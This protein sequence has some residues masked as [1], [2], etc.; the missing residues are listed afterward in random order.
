M[1]RLNKGRKD[2]PPL[3]FNILNCLFLVPGRVE[4]SFNDSK[5]PGVF[6]QILVLVFVN[7]LIN[8]L[9]RGI[10][11]CI[12]ANKKKDISWLKFNK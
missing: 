8:G 4:N 2:Q 12:T 5:R 9:Y 3:S 11:T 7:L 1:I 6:S 10:R